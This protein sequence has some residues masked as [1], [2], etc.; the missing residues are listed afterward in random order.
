MV[1]ARDVIAQALREQGWHDAGLPAPS[2]WEALAD[3]P[4]ERWLASADAVIAAVRSM[5]VEAVTE[6]VGG[7]TTGL[8]YRNPDGGVAIWVKR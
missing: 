7:S 3:G 5:P 2:T 1:N 4:R 6:L 8:R